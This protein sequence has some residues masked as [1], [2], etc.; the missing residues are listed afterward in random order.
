M[1]RLKPRP[2]GILLAVQKL[3]VR[4]FFMVGDLA[5]DI[6]A[7][8][9]AK[10]TAIVIRRDLEQSDSQDLLKSLP[11]E[12]LKEAKRA[13][14]KRGNLQADYVIQSLAE[15]PAIIQSECSR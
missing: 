15:I 1:R 10:G 13:I 7:A 8:K 14:E 3:G 5:L 12:V 11:E 9:R 2:E 6:L 4:R